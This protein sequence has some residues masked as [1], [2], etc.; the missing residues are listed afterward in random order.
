[1]STAEQLTLA[2]VRTLYRVD[3]PHT[4]GRAA[5]GHDASGGRMRHSELVLAVVVHHPGLTAAEIG[6]ATCLGHVAAQRRLSDL[7]NAHRVRQ[8]AARECLLNGTRM[9]TWFE[10]TP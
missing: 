2:P 3:D 1:M 6:A 9:V 7:K 4:S 10:V 5:D 8:G